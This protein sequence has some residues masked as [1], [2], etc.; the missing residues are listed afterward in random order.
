MAIARQKSYITPAVITLVLYFFLW[1]PGL[2]AN[3]FYLMDARKTKTSIG[4]NPS[5]MGCLWALLAWQMVTIVALCLLVTAGGLLAPFV[6]RLSYIGNYS[7]NENNPGPAVNNSG[8][9]YGLAAES[10]AIQTQTAKD[11]TELHAAFDSR[12]PQWESQ[13]GGNQNL[14]I[15][16]ADAGMT[17]DNNTREVLF[18]KCD[19]DFY[20]YVVENTKPDTGPADGEGYVYSTA[21]SPGTCHPPQW[22]VYDSEDVGGN[23]YFVTLQ[24]TQK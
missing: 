16:P 6:N 24:S 11:L 2:I 1:I 7:T 23:W 13:L 8:G 4:Q 9:S 10:P 5:G 17:Q 14:S 3:I 20:L 21:S 18:G 19:S 15:P 22:S 12:I